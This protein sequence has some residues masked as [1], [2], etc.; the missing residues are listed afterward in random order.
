MVG[1]EKKIPREKNKKLTRKM[2][3]WVIA[4]TKGTVKRYRL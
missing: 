1:L 3:K 4:L 2:Q